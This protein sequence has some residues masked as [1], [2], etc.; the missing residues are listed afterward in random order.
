[1]EKGATSGEDCSR[2]TISSQTESSLEWFLKVERNLRNVY[3]QKSVQMKSKQRK[4]YQV[5]E[6]NR[7]KLYYAD[8]CTTLRSTNQKKCDAGYVFNASIV[9]YAMGGSPE[10]LLFVGAAG[11]KDGGERMLCKW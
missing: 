10:R 1:M 6:R 7:K 4:T 3:S 8:I 9:S 5:H 11:L 2:S